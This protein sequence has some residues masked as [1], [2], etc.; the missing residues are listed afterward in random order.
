[1][2]TSAFVSAAPLLS[3]S[4]SRLSVTSSA[5]SSFTSR[6]VRAATAPVRRAATVMMGEKEKVP[7]GFTLFS[8]QLNGRAAMFGFILAV[9]TEALTGKG[10]L[11]QLAALGD[12]S[13]VTSA[14]GL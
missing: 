6:P 7:Q 4:S 2:N 8:E 5:Y 10:I 1:M 13:N 11:G 14:L 9:A 12:I 3:T